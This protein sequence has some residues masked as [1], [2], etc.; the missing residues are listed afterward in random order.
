MVELYT[1]QEHNCKLCVSTDVC[2]DSHV[3]CLGFVRS[4]LASS[5]F[6]RR[7]KNGST[8]IKTFKEMRYKRETVDADAPLNVSVESLKRHATRI[9]YCEHC[10]IEFT[11]RDLDG[12]VRT[13]CCEQLLS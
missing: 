6:G 7:L 8:R 10:S 5:V 11:S 2:Q 4:A 12:K 1:G 13:A 9:F 3:C